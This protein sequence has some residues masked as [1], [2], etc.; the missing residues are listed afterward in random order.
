[1]NISTV[2]IIL[3]GALVG[4]VAYLVTYVANKNKKVSKMTDEGEN[5]TEQSCENNEEVDE[6]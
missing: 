3:S 4:L 6:K 5:V 1:L 2:F